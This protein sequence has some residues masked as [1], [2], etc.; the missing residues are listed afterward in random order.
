MIE[1]QVAEKYAQALF[2]LAQEEDNL[3]ATLTEFADLTTMVQESEEL[4]Q[5]LHHPELTGEQKKELFAKVF[6]DELSNDLFNFVKLLIDKS[7]ETLLDLIYQQFKKLVDKEANRL[8]VEVRS[9]IEL[10]QEQ[11][12]RLQTK[13]AEQLNKDIKLEVEIKPDL[14]GGLV[15]KIGDKIIDGSLASQLE[16]LNQN[17][18]ELEVS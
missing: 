7:R 4:N 17:L 13:L 1:E 15:L 10:S 8:E 12:E 2:E 3:E 6:A 9:P 14:I 11:Q 16:N 5:V 18:K